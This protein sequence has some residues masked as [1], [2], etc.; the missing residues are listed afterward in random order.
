VGRNIYFAGRP[1]SLAGYQNQ[2]QPYVGMDRLG[3]IRWSGDYQYHTTKFSY[4]P[5]GE[6]Y[7]TSAQEREKFG[8]YYRDG[9]TGLDYA[10][11]RYYA[12]TYGRFMTADPYINSA[13]TADPASWNRYAYTRNDPVNRVDLS[14]LEDCTPS[15]GIDFCATGTAALPTQ[16]Y[17][18]TAAGRTGH[19]MYAYMSWFQLDKSG[20]GGIGRMAQQQAA[21]AAALAATDRLFDPDCAGLFLAP[22]ANT[23]EQR[24]ILSGQLQY[25]VDQG[26]VRVLSQTSLPA[27]TPPNVPA[28]TT[29]TLGFIYVIS[30]RSFFTGQLSGKPLGGAF[31]GLSLTRRSS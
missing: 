14:G 2:Y 19:S 15:S 11:N 18:L 6:E 31:Q 10:R 29:G 24:K 28:F 1:V 4:Y 12:S 5:Y 25:A 9:S 16:L 3:T 13:G 26:D 17:Y 27:E 23:P 21:N 30:E 8:T 22:D 20:G 7:T